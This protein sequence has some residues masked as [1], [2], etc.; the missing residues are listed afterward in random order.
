[1]STNEPIH[2]GE[3]S[4][5]AAVLKSPV[6]VLVDFWATWCGPCKMIA[7]ILDEIAREQAGKVRVAK[8]DVDQY[9]A[10]AARFNIRGIPTMILFQN[11]EAKETIVGLT[12]KQVL[13]AKLEA[14]A[15]AA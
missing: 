3:D 14:L 5:D 15:Q 8:I 7:P 6:P 9:P 11:G 2:V 13:L 10:L 1:M 4:F 12:G